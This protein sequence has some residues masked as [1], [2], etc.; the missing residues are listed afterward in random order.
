MEKLV[1]HAHMTSCTIKTSFFNK[2][3][4]SFWNDLTSSSPF[5]PDL[6]HRALGAYVVS[7]A[8]KLMSKIDS[9]A[10]VF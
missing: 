7:G 5:V 6:A 4:I 8:G 9:E 3:Q 10:S 1:T 2:N